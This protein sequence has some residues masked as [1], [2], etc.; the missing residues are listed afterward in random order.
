MSRMASAPPG[1]FVVLAVIGDAT[2]REAIVRALSPRY[3]VHA[4]GDGLEA[5]DVAARVDRLHLVVTD[6]AL[7]QLDGLRMARAVRAHPDR[8]TLPVVFLA[9]KASGQEA[10]ESLAVGGRA[11]LEKPVDAAEVAE[12][13]GHVLARESQRPRWAV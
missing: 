8:A 9:T 11:L 12:K 5:L 13:I 10:A 2:E 6:I 3:I 4:A 7:R 1:G